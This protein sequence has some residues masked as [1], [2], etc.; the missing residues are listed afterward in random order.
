MNVG[1][2]QNT[3]RA[4]TSATAPQAENADS[5]VGLLKLTILWRSTKAHHMRGGL[6][7]LL[8][9]GGYRDYKGGSRDHEFLVNC[10]ERS[11]DL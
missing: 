3:S 1:S 6:M 2:L 9:S 10:F 5:L 8:K 11:I 7:S 4:E